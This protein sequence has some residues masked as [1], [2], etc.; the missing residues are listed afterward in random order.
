MLRPNARD[1]GFCAVYLLLD[2]GAAMTQVRFR[3]GSARAAMLR[4]RRDRCR[5]SKPSLLR[6]HLPLPLLQ[7]QHVKE[8]CFINFADGCRLHPEFSGLQDDSEL[9]VRRV[10]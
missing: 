4:V 3:L 9:A 2:I 6:V 8:V 10:T 7:Q 5:L 1:A